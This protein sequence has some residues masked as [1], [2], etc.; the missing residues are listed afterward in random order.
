MKISRNLAHG[1]SVPFLL[2]ALLGSAAALA[3]PS[4][5]P[6]AA[7][8]ASP[9]PA[10]Q[11]QSALPAPGIGADVARAQAAELG[12][13]GYAPLPEALRDSLLRGNT[14]PMDVIARLAPHTLVDKLPR[15][16][17]FEWRIA[18]TD[19]LLVGMGTPVIAAVLPDVFK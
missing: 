18:G 5:E 4:P 10:P 8:A 19:L 2:A 14:M 3:E 12:F 16:D 13:T 6:A 11:K 15:H 17:G 1:L 9:P 7:P